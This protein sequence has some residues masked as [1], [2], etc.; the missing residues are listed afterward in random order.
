[1]EL[2]VDKT[3]LITE[4]LYKGYLFHG[5]T[6][7]N[8]NIFEPREAKDDDSTKEFN[9]DTAIFATE[10][11]ESAILFALINWDLIP[12]EF[13]DLTWGVNWLDSGIVQAELPQKWRNYMNSAKGYLYV[14]PSESFKT[15]TPGGGQYKSYENVKPNAMIEVTFQEFID[16]GG[17]V[18]W[19]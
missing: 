1:M 10:Y 16:L 13:I 4:Y 7:A 18:N 2:P 9:N 8:I 6:N 3:K 17:K 15:K 5:S 12:K 19:I 14:L 11:P